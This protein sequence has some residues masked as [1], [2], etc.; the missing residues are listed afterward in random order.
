VDGLDPLEVVTSSTVTPDGMDALRSALERAALGGARHDFVVGNV[1]HQ[2]ALRRSASSL[3]AALAGLKVRTPL[4]LVSFD[5]R[6]AVHAL[7]EITGAQVD[8]ELLDRIFRDF[9]IG[10]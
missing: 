9:C 3:Q 7:G 2:D 10:K 4:D 6:A 5:V 1:R 8:D